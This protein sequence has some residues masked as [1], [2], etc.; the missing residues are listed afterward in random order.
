MCDGVES[1]ILSEEESVS[2]AMDSE[3]SVSSD[4]DISCEQSEDGD[5]D[6]SVEFRHRRPVL[7][8]DTGSD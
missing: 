1:F 8:S 4:S 5:S 2:N 7:I 3:N 6:F